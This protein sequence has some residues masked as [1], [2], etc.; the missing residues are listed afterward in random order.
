MKKL[1]KVAAFVLFPT[2]LMALFEIHQRF[3]GH[4]F[5]ELRVS[6]KA[7]LH[8]Y[9]NLFPVAQPERR[10]PFTLRAKVRNEIKKLEV[11]DF[12][13]D[14]KNKPSSWLIPLVV[15]PKS[16]NVELIVKLRNAT[17]FSKLHL[18]KAFHQFIYLSFLLFLSEK[19][20]F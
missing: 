10:I 3:K 13:E 15:V 17:R 9:K 16:E 8:I 6:F 11:N 20:F 7:M 19:S 1:L 5:N 12:I 14:I 2:S 18:N 4:F